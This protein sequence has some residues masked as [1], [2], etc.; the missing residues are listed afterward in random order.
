MRW[1]HASAV[2]GGAEM[3]SPT[4]EE[5][6]SSDISQILDDT[7]DSNPN[8]IR[9]SGLDRSQVRDALEELL[10]L[11]KDAERLNWLDSR[12]GFVTDGHSY[13][14]PEGELVTYRWTVEEQCGDIRSAIDEAMHRETLK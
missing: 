11:R 4:L 13:S 10:E 8:L 7:S 12:Y 1:L 9:G 6:I 5:L 3:S 2:Y 14:N